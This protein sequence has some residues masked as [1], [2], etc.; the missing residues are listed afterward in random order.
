MELMLDPEI[1][2]LAVR[3]YETRKASDKEAFTR[4]LSAGKNN[5]DLVFL[6]LARSST[7]AS[8]CSPE[9]I[10]TAVSALRACP[11]A[12]WHS[13]VS[14]VTPSQGHVSQLVPLARKGRS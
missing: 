3:A 9:R 5:A 2:A 13:L 4:R 8:S 12:C 11:E 1:Q 7:L 6:A 10:R 14:I